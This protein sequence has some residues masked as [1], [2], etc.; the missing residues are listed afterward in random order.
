[1]DEREAFTHQTLAGALV[2]G[3]VG[4]VALFLLGRWG[5][6]A[7]FSLGAAVSLGNFH[8]IAR[9]VRGLA[10]PGAAQ[11]SRHL[12]KGACLRFVIAGVILYVAVAV[13]RVSILALVAGLLSTQLA[14]IGF[15]LLQVARTTS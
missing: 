1:L 10:D 11:A 13:L 9:A 15:W 4:A 12:W 14:M 6:A 8:L 7:G 5:W 3:A 2:V